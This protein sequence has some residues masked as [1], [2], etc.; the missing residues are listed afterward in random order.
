MGTGGMRMLDLLTRKSH[1]YC[2]ALLALALV[3]GLPL[4]SSAANVFQSGFEEGSKAIWDDYDG[5]P[6]ETNL[7]MADPG[8]FNKAGNHVMRLR[9][10]AGRGGA[11]L[12]K[13]LPSAHDRLFLRWFQKWEDGYNFSAPNHGSG[14]HA[15]DRDS[16]GRSDYRPNGSDYFNSYL[17]PLNG[18]LNLYSYYRGM[19]QNCADP[20][21]SCWG[22]GF[23]CY[24]DQGQVFCTK[25]AHRPQAGKTPP[26]MQAGQWYCLE[27]MVDAGA[28]VSQEGQA[29]GV[30]DFW[31]NDVEYG[32]FQTLWHRTTA[33]LKL[34]IL[35]MNLFHHD[36]T[37]SVAGILLDDI[38]VSTE[39]VGCGAPPTVQPPLA[40]IDLRVNP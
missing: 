12:V 25:P 19:Y 14:L 20:N 13:V 39:R 38:V 23:P 11:D 15:G 18:K 35:W 36:A 28:A 8:P 21:G 32:P 4:L 24:A 29:N 30:Q 34:S 7:L 37:H 17:E 9:A 26:V 40:P 3:A 33:D 16:L 31:I 1:P 10:P 22:D 2:A 5:N 27:M 6:D